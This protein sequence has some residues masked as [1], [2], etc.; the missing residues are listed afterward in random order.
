[1]RLRILRKTSFREPNFPPLASFSHA[2]ETFPTSASMKDKK[3][4]IYWLS[5]SSPSHRADREVITRKE[6]KKSG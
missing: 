2:V 6:E 1:V 4:I 3:S 5:S